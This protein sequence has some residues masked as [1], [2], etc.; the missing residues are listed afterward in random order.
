M[1]YYLELKTQKLYVFIYSIMVSWGIKNEI[2]S[3]VR[4]VN[5]HIG[6][7]LV[8]DIC[9]QKINKEGESMTLDNFLKV[10]TPYSDV[11]IVVL[12]KDKSHS[13]NGYKMNVI[14]DLIV[15]EKY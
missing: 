5:D 15:K 8:T 6:D 3:D 11:E 12:A 7:W 1:K 10:L 4:F 2:K 14:Q 13:V 9:V